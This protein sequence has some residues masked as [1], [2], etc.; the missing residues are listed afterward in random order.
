MCQG[1]SRVSGRVQGVMASPRCKSQSRGKGAK[2]SPRM[3]GPVQSVRTANRKCRA[4]AGYQ[5]QSRVPGSFID[6][7]AKI[8]DAECQ[9]QSEMHPRDQGQSK[10]PGPG[11]VQEASR[12]DQSKAPGPIRSARACPGQS[13]G[14]GPN[15]RASPGFQ[16]DQMKVPGPM[17]DTRASPGCQGHL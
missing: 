2:A 16:G 8:K 1:Q 11:P 17:Q 3:P 5:V 4:S 13:K 12:C 6:A 7:K 9:Y 15:A 10:V 14:P